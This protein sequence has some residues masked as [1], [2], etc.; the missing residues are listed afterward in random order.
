MPANVSKVTIGLPVYNGEATLRKVLD[1]ILTQTFQDFILIISDNCSTDRTES[2]CREYARNESRINYI[3][4]SENIGAFKNFRFV[5][6]LAESEYFSWAA[7]DDLK[8]AD[9]L[10]KNLDFLEKNPDFITSTSPSRFEN[11]GFNEVAMGDEPLDGK[12]ENRFIRF[13]SC[14]HANSRF[15][16]LFRRGPLIKSFPI[17]DQYLGADWAIMLRCCLLGKT[18][19]CESGYV[20]RGEN[21]ASNRKD[22]FK[23]SRNHWYEYF[24]PFAELSYAVMKMTSSFSLKS[25][26]ILTLYLT[27]INI[28]AVRAAWKL[29]RT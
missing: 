18:N 8:S 10:Q 28:E 27:K 12:V 29:S 22:I 5:L 1:S 17:E 13:F 15:Y 6:T 26:I 11:G 4:Q 19:V 9:F 3:R 7:A 25:R 14:W 21:G 24:L 2:I 16:G 20:V 23:K